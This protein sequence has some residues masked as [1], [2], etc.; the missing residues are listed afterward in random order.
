MPVRLRVA[1]TSMTECVRHDHGGVRHVSE[2][3][4]DFHDFLCDQVG[5]ID[6]V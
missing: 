3:R 6:R 1:H 5:G 4:D 2:R